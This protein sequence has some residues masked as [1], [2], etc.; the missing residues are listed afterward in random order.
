[1]RKKYSFIA[2]LLSIA[3][4]SQQGSILVYAQD[5]DTAEKTAASDKEYIESVLNLANNTEYTWSYEESEDA[6]IMSIVSAVAYPELPDQ[7]GVSVCV[8]GSYVS[9]IDTDKDGEAD[10]LAEDFTEAVN[11]SL[12]IDYEAQITSTNGQIYTAGSAPVILNTGAAGY[13]SS[14]N[15]LASAVY[16]KEG[17]INVA[18]GNRGKQDT[19]TDEEGNALS[20]EALAQMTDEEKAEAFLEGRYCAGSEKGMGMTGGNPGGRGALP[21]GEAPDG[22][23]PEIPAEQENGEEQTEGEMTGERPGQKGGLGKDMAAGEMAVGTPDAGTTQAAGSTVDSQN[24]DSYEEMVSSYAD[25]IAQIQ[26]GDAYGNNIL[27]LYNPLN[28]IG[29]EET[30]DAAWTRIVMGAAEGDMPMFTSLNLQIAWLNAGTDCEIEWQWD[31]GHVP[32]ETLSHSFALYVDHMYGEYAQGVEVETPQPEVQTTNGTAEEATGTDISEWVQAEDLS[33]V[34]F[35]LADAVSYRTNGAS[36]AMP[37][38]DVIDYGQEDYVFGSSTQDARHWNEI[39][40]K[41]F[42]EHEDT[43]AE[44]FN[45]GE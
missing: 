20:D 35:T 21:E 4:C 15:S 26:A 7:Q 23:L 38:F 22:E 11:G 10:I 44:L 6:W 45:S 30:E 8:P 32:S 36:K 27:S 33:D 17:Y 28:Y 31:G 1:M 39:L 19:V 14:V 18:C 12:V 34:S 37:G 13:G 29:D 42:T 40:L 9:D 16:A 5:A 24:Y 41:I 43:L 25:D 3:V 2:L